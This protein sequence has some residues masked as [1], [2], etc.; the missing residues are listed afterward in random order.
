MKRIYWQPLAKHLVQTMR[1]HK[2]SAGED[3]FK[4]IEV[5][6][7]SKLT[8]IKYPCIEITWDRETN[9][10]IHRPLQG[11]V[12]LW[13]DINIKN[14]SP[15]PSEGY[16]ILY[17]WQTKALDCIASWQKEIYAEL[18]IAAKVEIVDIISDGDTQRPVCASR[19]V[20]N[21]EWRNSI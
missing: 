11:N 12:I 17:Q 7:G 14:N 18:G 19:L 10:K 20:V 13:V 5:Y 8:G 4:G 3:I 1:N 9:I 6:T 2:D 15:D 16:E 21:I